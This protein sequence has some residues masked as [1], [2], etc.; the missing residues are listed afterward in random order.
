MKINGARPKCGQ[1]TSLESVELCKCPLKMGW[2]GHHPYV[3][4]F[5]KGTRCHLDH[6]VREKGHA[7]VQADEL[8]WLRWRDS[9]VDTE[10]I[11]LKHEWHIWRGERRRRLA[12][13]ADYNL[14]K[15]QDQD[16][17][18]VEYLFD[19]LSKFQSSRM[20]DQRCRFRKP[21]DSEEDASI[22]L[23]SLQDE[24][25]FD[26]ISCS[27]SHRLDDQRVSV[28]NLPGFHITHNNLGLL[29]GD[30]D[31]PEPGDDFFNMLI[32]CQSSRIDDQRC[33]PPDLGPQALT[34]PD[35]DLFSLIQRMQAKRMDEQRVHLHPEEQ[36]I[37]PPSGD[38]S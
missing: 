37:V 6:P 5:S 24:E 27:Q 23:P 2:N 26:L 19:L 10:E 14:A 21:S 16:P 8:Q 15:M 4:I 28:S 29:C 3:D 30:G 35:E 25:L 34:V 36:E 7:D 22:L 32:K 20:D 1:R 11:S 31:P 13:K 38:S 9:P 18:S 12:L 33:S 17:S